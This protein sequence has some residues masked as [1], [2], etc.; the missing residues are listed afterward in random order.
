MDATTAMNFINNDLVYKPD[1][2]I[3]ATCHTHRFNETVKVTFQFTCFNTNR[4][5]VQRGVQHLSAFR[6]HV[7][8]LLP[9]GKFKT[10]DDLMEGMLDLILR[11]EEHEARE[12]LR[13]KREG[14]RAPFHPH[15]EECMVEYAERKGTE[16][17]LKDLLYGA[18]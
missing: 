13:N 8:L 3:E 9:V 7:A 15:I 1:W 16:C 18:V 17:L 10:T 5:V 14:F 4:E 11:V 12:F 2:D 6:N